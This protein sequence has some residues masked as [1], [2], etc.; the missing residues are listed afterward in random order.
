[1]H[2]VGITVGNMAKTLEFYIEVLGGRLIIAEEGL[3]GD[4]MQNTLFQKEELDAARTGMEPATLGVPDLRTGRQKLDVYFVQF[5]NV[6][7]ELLQYRESSAAP[8]GANA[9]PAFHENSS[10]AY[11]NSMHVS[12]LLTEDT[13]VNAFVSEIEAE[14]R[15]RGMPNVR[16][17]RIAQVRSEEERLRTNAQFNACSLADSAEHSFGDFDGWTLVY[18]KGPNGEQLEFNQL[19]R[20][21]KRVFNSA[22]ENFRR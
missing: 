18:M 16:C 3:D 1:M 13:D 10:A 15:R 4:V 20:K 9:F 2:H 12:F 14:C 6:V 17:N 5:E 19:R 22:K 11:V 21:A 8:R 7:L